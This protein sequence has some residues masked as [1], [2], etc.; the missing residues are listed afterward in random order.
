MFTNHSQW[1][2]QRKSQT[3]PLS[4]SAVCTVSDWSSI[5]MLIA[6]SVHG[7]DWPMEQPWH[8]YYIILDLR[9]RVATPTGQ[10]IGQ[11]PPKRVK[12]PHHHPFV[13]LFLPRPQEALCSQ[14]VRGSVRWT[15]RIFPDMLSKA[16]WTLNIALSVAVWQILPTRFMK[17]K[18]TQLRTNYWLGLSDTLNYVRKANVRPIKNG[19]YNA[20]QWN[21]MQLHT[22]THTHTHIYIMCVCVCVFWSHWSD[23]Q[24]N[25]MYCIILLCQ[26]S[27]V[28]HAVMLS[29]L[30]T[31]HGLWSPDWFDSV[32]HPSA[33]IPVLLL[34]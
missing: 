24:T 27:L 8:N 25:C 22:H 9:D 26:D 7:K 1:S 23:H 12:Y 32:W 2:Q 4:L 6:C 17:Q 20:G 16:F 5:T 28:P 18:F 10:Q 14:P 31:K 13:C 34:S 11:F 30:A 29:E 33:K 3:E 15:G 19:L 21:W